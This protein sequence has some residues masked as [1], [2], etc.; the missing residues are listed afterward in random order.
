MSETVEM[1]YGDNHVFSQLGFPFCQCDKRFQPPPIP[2]EVPQHYG[3]PTTATG[4]V[5]P[6]CGASLAPSVQQCPNCGPKYEKLEK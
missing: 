6:Q 4:W 3:M 5:C 1:C 2:K